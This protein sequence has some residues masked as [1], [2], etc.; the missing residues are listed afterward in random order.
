MT[1]LCGNRLQSST[2]SS[3]PGVVV[4]TMRSVYDKRKV[5]SKKVN[6]KSSKQFKRFSWSTIF[7]TPNN[8][9]AVLKTINEQSLTI[10]GTRVLRSRDGNDQRT[11]ES[12]AID[13]SSEGND[14]RSGKNGAD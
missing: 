2:N 14:E 9:L 10:K 13:E 4:V 5:L 11:T 7:H 12:V 3:K 8:L 1:L 6:L